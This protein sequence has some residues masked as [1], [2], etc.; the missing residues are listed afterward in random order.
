MFYADMG[1][2]C[3]GDADGLDKDKNYRVPENSTIRSFVTNTVVPS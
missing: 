1:V 2:L 3:A